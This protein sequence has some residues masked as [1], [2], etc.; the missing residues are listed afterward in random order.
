MLPKIIKNKVEQ[1]I[2]LG[3]TFGKYYK[4]EVSTSNLTQ[5]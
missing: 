1:Q 4:R 5:I 3:Q 2:G